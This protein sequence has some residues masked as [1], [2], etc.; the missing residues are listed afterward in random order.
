MTLSNSGTITAASN[1]ALFSDATALQVTN[2]A[3]ASMTASAGHALV[4]DNID[5]AT[6]TIMAIS[7]T[8]GTAISM[9]GDGAVEISGT[10]S[11]N[12]S[13]ISVGSDAEIVNLGTINVG[14]ANV[15]VQFAGTGSVL[16]LSQ[17][18]K[19][20]S[21]LVAPAIAEEAD[22]HELVINLDAGLSYY[23]FDGAGIKIHR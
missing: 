1:A 17:D 7:A 6:L 9:T 20:D 23:D 13:G 3:N 18:A 12:S 15:A 5:N 16:Q 19:A 4:A 11:G 8:G 14:T 10:I 21:R 22:R 2:A